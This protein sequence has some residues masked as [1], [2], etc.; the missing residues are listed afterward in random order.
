MNLNEY[1]EKA[2]STCTK[3]SANVAYMAFNL[4]AEAGE[5]CGK[6]AKQV[7]RGDLNFM[8]NNPAS[9]DEDGELRDAVLPELG[10]VLWQVAGLCNVLDLSLEDVAQYNLLKLQ[11]RQKRGVIVGSG[12]SR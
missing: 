7:R 3:T 9:V 10:D 2:Y 6:I 4:A 11:D 8:D 5:V 12:D 1:Q